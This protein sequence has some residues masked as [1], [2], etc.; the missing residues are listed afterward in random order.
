MTTHLYR[1]RSTKH[2]LGEYQE[3]RH[4]Q[5]YF[6]EPS[7]LNDPME[8]FRDIV[9]RGDEIVWANLFRNYISCLNLTVTL[10][11][12]CGDTKLI[13]PKEILIE[14]F[15]PESPTPIETIVLDEL[16]SS[17]FELCRLN[18]LISSLANTDHK[19]RR[20]ELLLYLKAVHYIALE[21]IQKIHNRH[22]GSPNV[23]TNDLQ[24]SHPRVLSQITDLIQQSFR[25][26]PTFNSSKRGALF[27]TFSRVYDNR[28]LIRKY[29]TR[30]HDKDD[31]QI[32]QPNQDLIYLDFP[33]VYISQLP[34]ILYPRYYVACFLEDYRNSSLWGHYGDNHTGACLIFSARQ[35]SGPP[36]LNLR[37]MVGY[38]TFKDSQSGEFGSKET[39]KYSPVEFYKMN[40][41][42]RLAELDFFRSIGFLRTDTLLSRWYT[43]RDGVRSKCSD[44]IGAEGEELWRDLYW[45]KFFRDLTIKTRDWSYEKEWRLVL[46]SSLMDL[47]KTSNRTLSYKF[48]D[49]KGIIFG[50]NMSDEDKM[51]IIDIILEKCRQMDRPLFEFYQAYY[52]EE[53]SSIERHKLDICIASM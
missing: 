9:W 1:I 11:K 31:R 17:V 2:L 29:Q 51:D 19:V 50:I 8:G 22:S 18:P 43:D 13:T 4:Q 25:Q 46:C 33:K 39:W 45:K 10:A 32:L 49:L 47:S 40:Y 53:S 3:L 52:S 41:Q 37:R 7:E 21:E 16:C 38:S 12:L 44:H 5:I 30:Q 27:S 48:E 28:I 15:D 36:V 6:A 42:E 14:G 24:R 26:D 34:R 20:D 35:V 23:V